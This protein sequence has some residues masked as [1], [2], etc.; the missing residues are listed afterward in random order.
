MNLIYRVLVGIVLICT[1]NAVHAQK[2][3]NEFLSIG[4]GARAQALGNAVVAQTN[5]VTAGVWNPAGLAANEDASGIQIG[6]MH[7]E[8]FAGVGK[9]DYLGVMLPSSNDKRRL[10]I[11]LIRFGVDEIPNTLTLYESDGTVNFDNLREFSA[12]D[13]ALLLS[14]AQKSQK[15]EGQWFWGG[16]VKVIHR[17]IGPFANSW[18][19][20]LDGGVQYRRGNFRFGALAKDITTSFNAWSFNFTAEEKQTLELTNNEIPINSLEIT[21]PQLVLGFAQRFQFKKIGLT[22][23]LDFIVST[24][25]KRNTL[26]SANPFSIDPAIGIEADLNQTVFLRVGMNQFQKET[27]FEGKSVLSPRPGLG[28]GLKISNLQVDYAFTDLAAQEN[29]YSHII[30]LLLNLKARK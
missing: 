12:A 18:G 25:G 7:A 20:G 5:D 21:K 27:S 9:F 29:T 15:R 23:E 2:Y 19:F 14:Y 4:V 17:R 11:S 8:W 22:P 3:S 30:S 6:A 26:L 1:V 28:V 24:D 13:Y 10:G 16:S